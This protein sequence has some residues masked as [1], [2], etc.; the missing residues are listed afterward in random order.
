MPG[1]GRETGLNNFLH[2]RFGVLGSHTNWTKR[3]LILEDPDLEIHARRAEVAV[4]WAQ[5]LH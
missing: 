5:M 1:C 4:G 3:W 2:I